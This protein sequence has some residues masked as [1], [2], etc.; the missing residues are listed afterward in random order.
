MT[1]EPLERD[2][3]GRPAAAR[4]RVS[5]RLRLTGALIA[6]VGIVALMLLVPGDGTGG[7]LGDAKGDL[8]RERTVRAYTFAVATLL[9][10]IALLHVMS[11]RLGDRGFLDLFI[12]ADRRASTSKTQYLLWTFGIAFVLCYIGAHVVLAERAGLAAAFECANMSSSNCVRRGSWDQYLVL[13]GIPAGA[14]VLAK[15]ITSYKVES[16][17]LQKTVAEPSQ[18]G[19]A[20]SAAADD[21]GKADIVDVQYLVFNLVAFV[22]VAVVFVDRGVLDS[23]PEILLGLTGAAGATYVLNKSLQTNVPVIQSVVPTVITPGTLVTVHGANLFS[24]DH[25]GGRMPRAVLIGGVEG[26]DV[27]AN[28]QRQALTFRAP[29]GMSAQVPTVAVVTHAGVQTAPFTVVV[30]PDLTVLT[31]SAARWSGNSVQFEMFVQGL[32][33]AVRTEELRDSAVLAV[34]VGTSMAQPPVVLRPGV[35]Q[36]TVDEGPAAGTVPVRVTYLGRALP[37]LEL[38]V[39]PKQRPRTWAV[40]SRP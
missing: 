12:G 1:V 35:L 8:Q 36:L 14:A 7:W 29:L 23:V 34:Q 20:A 9:A 19:G 40:A 27:K 30:Q 28:V 10:A 26:I 16:G 22:Y 11:R 32:P 38:V 17:T 15:G 24:P 18:T 4:S 6:Y 39:P 3:D 25:D 21:N 13:L 5:S 33:A 31:V 37:A 2:K